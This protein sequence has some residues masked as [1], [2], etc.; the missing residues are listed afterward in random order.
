MRLKCQDSQSG[1]CSGVGLWLSL[2]LRREAVKRFL[3]VTHDQKFLS[4]FATLQ[5]YIKKFVFL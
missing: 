2:V 1:Y 4:F 3:L 5:Y